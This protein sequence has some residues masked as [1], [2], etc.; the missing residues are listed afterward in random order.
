MSEKLTDR[1]AL[2]YFEHVYNRVYHTEHNKE[3]F[4]TVNPDGWLYIDNNLLIIE[5]KQHSNQRNEA[6]NQLNRYVDIA[7]KNTSLINIYCMFCYGTTYDEFTIECYDD[8]LQLINQQTVFN[9][10]KQCISPTNT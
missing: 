8:N 2:N 7:K 1:L 4:D 6:L 9:I 3:L 10:F 5:N